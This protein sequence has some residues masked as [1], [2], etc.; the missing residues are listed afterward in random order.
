M[1][2]SNYMPLLKCMRIKKAFS[3]FW[4]RFYPW[5]TISKIEKHQHEFRMFWNRV[6]QIAELARKRGAPIAIEWLRKCS[7]W[8][9]PEVT[10][11]YSRNTG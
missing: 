10:K 1:S 4:K 11:S 5:E 8:K 3:F 7:Y 6:T 9:L 2:L